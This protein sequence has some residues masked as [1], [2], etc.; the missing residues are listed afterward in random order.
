MDKILEMKDKKIAILGLGIEGLALYDFLKKE[1]ANI[2]VLDGLSFEEFKKQN[3]DSSIIN[4]I[5]EGRLASIFGEEYLNSLNDFDI[6]FR[7][8]GISVLNSKIVD[9]L[10][11]GVVIHSQIKLFFDLCPCQIIG[12][13]GTKGKGTTSTLIYEII[14]E[15]FKSN[16]VDRKV[17]IAGNIGYP[18]VTLLEKLKSDDIVILELS[19]F[20]LMDLKKSPSISVITNLTVDHLNY[21]KDPEE[22]RNSKLSIIKYQN[23]GDFSVVNIKAEK[24]FG[25][26]TI[27]KS[28]VK[29]F[30]KE[31][32][33]DAIVNTINGHNCVTLAKTNEI[34]CQDNELKI[35]GLHNLENIAAAV[36]VC[37]KLKINHD[38]MKN[39]IKSFKGLP[40]RLEVIRVLDGITYINDSFA[41]NPEPT[42]AAIDAVIGSKILILGG[43]SKGA[44]FALLSSKIKESAVKAVVLIG[45]EAQNIRSSLIKTGF[46]GNIIMGG[47]EMSEIIKQ[48]KDISTNG[49]SII[50]SPACASFGLFKDYKD[51]GDKFRAGV[52]KLKSNMN[53]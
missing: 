44:D 36:L 41:T 50:L 16:S 32:D 24:D 29:Y 1:V 22:Y 39:V 6:V 15:S 19:S 34:I 3:P 35:I 7:T 2:T 25:L 4:D 53:C 40:H 17:Y 26:S 38:L 23:E 45:D 10:E 42:L 20:Q 46:E 33:V 43:S 12:V 18:A 28:E 48:A 8:P 27:T 37:D 31:G 21:H 11:N 51:R 5:Q 9:A 30:G 49:D 13:T 52:L 14:K 47:V